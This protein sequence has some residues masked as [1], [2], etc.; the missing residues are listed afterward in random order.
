MKNLFKFINKSFIYI[1]TFLLVLCITG[2]EEKPILVTEINVTANMT[3]KKGE[4]QKLDIEVLPENATNKDV[5]IITNNTNI[6]ILESNY[7]SATSVGE[8]VITITAKDESKISK[9]ITIKVNDNQV[10]VEKNIS[11][12]INGKSEIKSGSLTKLEATVTSNTFD[13]IDETVSWCI[14]KGEEYATIDE[15]GNLQAKDVD[16]DKII[17]VKATSNEDNKCYGSKII[18]IVSKPV[19]TDE[20]LNAFDY[21][22]V[23]FE[24]YVNIDLYTIGIT[25]KKYSSHVLSIKTA[26]DGTYWYAEYVDGSSDTNMAIYFKNH[27]NY[28]CQVSLN[29]LN[30]EEYTPM[31]DDYGNNVKWEDGGLYNNLS[32]LK[33]SDFKFN[34]DTWRY[35][36][37]GNDTKLLEKIVASSNPYDFEP[38]DL[39]LIIEEGEVMGVS[40][41]SAPDYTIASG[42]KA[43]QQLVVVIDNS[44]NVKVPKITK[45]AHMDFHDDLAKAIENMNSLESYELDFRQATNNNLVSDKYYTES[46]FTELITNELCYFKPYG[47]SYN[48]KGEEVKEFVENGNYGYKKIRDN[49]YNSYNQDEDGTYYASR[50]FNTDFSNAKPSFAFSAEIFGSYYVDKKAGTTTYY[51]YDLMKTVASTFYHGVGNDI[52]LYGIYAQEGFTTST[53]FTPFVVVKDGYIVEACFYFYLGY[54]YGVVDITYSNFNGASVPEDLK[55]EFSK[56]EVPTSWNELTIEVTDDFSENNIEETVNAMEYM[57]KFFGNN[58]IDNYIPFFGNPLGDTYGFGM[59]TYYTTAKSKNVQAILFYYDVPLGTDYSINGPI[60]DIEDYLEGL[61]FENV[62][63]GEFYKD[64][65]YVAPT[66]SQLDLIIYVWKA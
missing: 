19:L 49:L 26:M 29:F 39:S 41:N 9:E 10:I 38:T 6:N 33:A 8:T 15:F 64:G 35:E 44:E 63:N 17:E 45:Y 34:S 62:G 4:I 3:M 46:G 25:E 13:T 30:D 55:V 22:K 60:R 65:L 40:L 7:I 43:L 32:S 42:Y 47:I 53:S 24:G 20:M 59:T 52:N 21:E 23:A 31:T 66:D 36:Y 18:T 37:V 28:A 51:S 12:A 56:R 27:N 61:G 16:G 5:E 58:D 57:E 14:S 54:L 2:C 48:T 1:L 11:V 50:A